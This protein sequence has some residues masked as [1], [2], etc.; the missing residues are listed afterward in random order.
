MSFE[1]IAKQIKENGYA[2]VPDVIEREKV[3]HCKSVAESGV[4]RFAQRTDME[5]ALACRDSLFSNGENVDEETRNQQH[6]VKGELPYQGRLNACFLDL[7][8]SPN[9]VGLMKVLIQDANVNIHFPPMVR[10]KRKAQQASYV[11][12]HQDSAYFPHLKNF[13]ISWIPLQDI[14]GDVKGLEVI[15]GSH[16]VGNKTIHGDATWN[17]SIP[18]E[19]ITSLSEKRQAQHLNMRMGDVLVFNPWLIHRSAFESETRFSVDCRWFGPQNEYQK[20]Y[21]SFATRRVVDAY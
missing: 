1:T 13:F 16:V 21:Y 7:V 11:P 6:L 19:T 18:E 15:P 14:E 5:K 17:Y 12:W 20:R 9:L 10:F 2:V 8:S 4:A 3:Q